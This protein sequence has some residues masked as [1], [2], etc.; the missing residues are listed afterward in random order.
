MIPW[1]ASVENKMK[2]IELKE[3]KYRQ[4][5]KLAKKRKIK[6][7]MSKAAIVAALMETNEKFE[8]R[9]ESPG[10]VFLVIGNEGLLHI[11][12]TILGHL[13]NED[14]CSMRNE[15]VK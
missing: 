14:L 1:F 11:N 10:P 12:E 5:Q 4:L 15:I 8:N 3:M 6:A 13:N 2:L 7:N 9:I